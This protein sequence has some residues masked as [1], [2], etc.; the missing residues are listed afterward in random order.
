MRDYHDFEQ[1]MMNAIFMVLWLISRPFVWV[2][3]F[4]KW[5]IVSVA[6]E[7]GNRIVKIVGGIVAVGII[8]FFVKFL[9]L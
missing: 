1:L 6:K 7:T 5:F 8:G 2:Y 9:S 3:S 4:F